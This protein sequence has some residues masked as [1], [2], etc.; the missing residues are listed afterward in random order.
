MATNLVPNGFIAVNLLPYRTVALRRYRREFWLLLGAM[1]LLVLLVVVLAVSDWQRTREHYELYRAQLAR[2]DEALAQAQAEQ[3]AV[4]R[5]LKSV[6]SVRAQDLLA[7]SR[8]EWQLAV[9][10]HTLHSVPKGI[11]VLGFQADGGHVVINGSAQ[12]LSDLLVFHAI[13][14]TYWRPRASVR[15]APAGPIRRAGLG[16]CCDFVMHVRQRPHRRLH[17]DAQS[18]ELTVF[19]A[20]TVAASLFCG[21]WCV[22]CGGPG[23]CSGVRQW[24]V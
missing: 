4:T 24:L 18:A 15:I 12:R 11:R 17:H 2:V 7:Q 22:G 3:I 10:A 6:T 20:T 23:V 9:V 14:V 5:V 13:L 8:T 16:R 21:V 19:I 1:V